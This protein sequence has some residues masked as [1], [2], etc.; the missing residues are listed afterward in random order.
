M[1]EI[2]LETKIAEL[3]NDYEGMKDTLIKINPKFKKLNN[4]V[5]RRTLA[6]VASVKQAAIVGGMS[7]MDLLNQLRI[8][9]GQTPITLQNEETSKE[10]LEIPTWITQTPKA[11]INANTLLENDE[12]PL[13]KSFAL[14][15]TLNDGDILTIT[16]DFKPEPLIEEFEKKGYEVYSQKIETDN[17]ITY[18]KK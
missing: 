18:I 2:T 4:P 11:T 17:F 9:V 12:N 16:S 3:L 1:K 8:S 7:P 6:K 5:L 15:K 13:A 14:L 10:T